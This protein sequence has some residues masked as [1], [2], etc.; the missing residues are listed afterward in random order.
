MA[1]TKLTVNIDPI[2]EKDFRDLLVERGF[3]SIN[4]FIL[5]TLKADRA[6]KQ[7]LKLQS[8]SDRMWP[9]GAP[10]PEASPRADA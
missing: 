6:A 9:N 4:E 5:A 7:Q 2:V 3:P 1:D 8:I 10:D